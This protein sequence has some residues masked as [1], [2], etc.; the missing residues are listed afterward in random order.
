ML[1]GYIQAIVRDFH[2]AEDVFQDASLVIVKKGRELRDEREF[3][4]WARKVARFEALNTLRKQNRTPDLLEP[5]M[6]DLVDPA[7]DKDEEAGRAT[8]ALR[9]CLQRLPDRARRLIDLRYVAGL[10]G[11]ALA[12]RLNQPPNTVYVALSRIY[13]R[14]S[15]CVKKRL[16]LEG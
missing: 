3:C 13:R 10:S 4:A 7:W 9:D 2:L 14:L 15:S 1:L 5:A 16:A 12:A 6:L 8:L 11:K